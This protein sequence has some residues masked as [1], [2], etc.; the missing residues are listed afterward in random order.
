MVDCHVLWKGRCHV[1]KVVSSRQILANRA[2]AKKS[3]GPV[4]AVGKERSARN[5]LKHGLLSAHVVVAGGDEA[6]NPEEFQT[7][8]DALLDKFKPSDVIERTLVERVAGCFWRLR[9]AQRFEAGAIRQSL[10]E[11]RCD[12]RSRNDESQRLAFDMER[13]RRFNEHR[14]EDLQ[15]LQALDLNDPQALQNALPMLEKLQLRYSGLVWQLGA[16]QMCEVLLRELPRE[17]RKCDE[18]TIPALQHRLEEARKCHRLDLARRAL[19]ASLPAP[20]E[21]LKLVRY[22]NML[23]RQLHRALDQ[24]HRRQKFPPPG[25]GAVRDRG[26][27]KDA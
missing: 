25:Q 13:E 21:V 4:T 20:E 11:G 27:K 10:D 18:Q 14:R 15:Y 7:L 22:E 2:N 23:D 5:A 26:Q 9:R 24:L 19:T 16:Q 17:I 8:L 3:T 12:D 1:P 6:E